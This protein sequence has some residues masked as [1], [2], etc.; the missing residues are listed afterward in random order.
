MPVSATVGW[1]PISPDDLALKD[2]PKEP[3][4][5]AMIL[6]REV[7][8]DARQANV[9][10]DSI[11]EYVRIKIFTQAGT[12]FG[13][14]EI[15]YDQT[16]ETVPYVAGRTILPDGTIKDFDGQVLSSTIARAGQSEFFAKT[17]TLPDVQPGCIVEYRYD[18]QS[19]PGWI[20]NEKWD[21]SGEM[22]TR[23]AHF[24]YYPNDQFGEDGIFPQYR[25]YLL[26]TGAKMNENADHSYSMVLHDVSA[27]VD[28]PLM[29]PKA[30]LEPNV[31]FYYVMPGR[32]DPTDP[33]KKFWSHYAKTW[34]GEISHFTDKKDA[35]N[36]ELSKI[37]AVGDSPETKLRKIY[38]RVERIRNLSMEDYRSQKETK[39]EDLKPDDNVADVL[40][41]GYATGHQIN[42]TFIGL[43]RAAGF[44][45][46]EVYIAPR[47]GSLFF[48]NRNE[49]SELQADL[50][51]VKAGSQEYYLDPSA[52]FYPFGVLPWY[53]TEA[54]GIRV[55]GHTPT[56]ITTPEPTAAQ[57]TIERTAS[58]NVTPDGS[59]SANVQIDF[60]GLEGAMMRSQYRKEDQT[61]RTKDLE[62]TVK[63]WLPLGSELAVT[64]IDNWD[65]IEKPLHVE[66]T[67]KV[68]S[69]GSTTARDMLL[70]LDIF[71]ATQA[72]DFSQQTRHNPVYF[73]YPYEE[74]DNIT[75]NAPPGYKIDALPKPQKMDLKAAVY[76]IT[77][78]SR[79]NSVEVTRQLT[80]GGVLFAKEA[81]PTFR[82][83]FGAVRTNDNAQMVL[84]NAQTG[85]LQ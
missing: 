69:Y 60:T 3:G 73:P 10:G 13:H 47:N 7:N 78:A 82:A 32:P 6:Y 8:I 2:N 45:A 40:N 75:V 39:A 1:L 46:T 44:D 25:N 65:D 77:P 59:I 14:V 71:Q 35:L 49:V 42:L 64:K 68:A 31:E 54:G 30:V 56:V 85:Q 9:S 57:A 27:V 67:L 80:I 19:R 23:E 48:A 38:A 51:W 43:A 24:T 74:I 58:L 81:Y 22:Y 53:E 4:A 37:V 5:D 18:V 16:W 11:E 36:Q 17:F 26:P 12:K 72:G 15:P 21:L 62:S 61:G 83:F 41:R 55:D 76:Q 52:R 20:T 70:P 29:P 66:A 79:G 63:A 33:P 28:E 50:V 84:E 34:D